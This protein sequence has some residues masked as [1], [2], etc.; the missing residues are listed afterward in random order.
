MII[1]GSQGCVRQFTFVKNLT[2][3]PSPCLGTSVPFFPPVVL[4]TTVETWFLNPVLL[5][6]LQACG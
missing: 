3:L 4:F 6:N 1:P 2:V 5:G